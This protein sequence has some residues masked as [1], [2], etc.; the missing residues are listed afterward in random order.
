MQHLSTADI[1]NLLTASRGLHD[2]LLDDALWHTLC[3]SR[4]GALT[5][6]QRWVV[7]PL[8]PTTPGTPGRVTLPLPQTFR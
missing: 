6:V 7:P 1:H 4:W 5:D 8:P 2:A 3:I